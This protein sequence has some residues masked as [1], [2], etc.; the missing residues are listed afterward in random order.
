MKDDWT[1]KISF[2]EKVAFDYAPRAYEVKCSITQNG[3][4]AIPF[5]KGALETKLVNHASR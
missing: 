4:T 5:W 2:A 3:P 1:L